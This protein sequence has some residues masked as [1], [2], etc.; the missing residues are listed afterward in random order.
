M[1]LRTRLI[2]SFTVVVAGLVLCLVVFISL[3]N[4]RQVQNYMLRGGM[5]GFQDTV[6][7]LEDFYRTHG[8]WDGVD[9]IL[10]DS[11]PMN[12]MR[13]NMPG[14]PDRFTLTDAN[15]L[16]VWS[17]AGEKTGAKLETAVKNQ[18]IKLESTPGQ[19][20]G[21]LIVS[22]R[23]AFQP[24]QV[25]PLITTLRNT[26]LRIGLI[27]GL[28]ALILA[29]LVANR[30][31]KPVKILTAAADSLSH[32]DL[33][34]RVKLK[35]KD[36]IAGLGNTFNQMAENLEGAEKRKK[37][38]TADIAHELRSP[39]AVQKAQLEAMQDGI[40]P[41][42]NESLQT[43]VDQTNFLTRLVDDLRTLALVDASELPLQMEE[44]NLIKLIDQVVERF[45]LQAVQQKVT[46]EFHNIPGKS[47]EPVNGDPD[48]LTQ[49]FGNLITNALHHTQAQGS[50]I[51]ELN[52]KKESFIASIKDTGCGIPPEELPHLFERFYRGDKSRNRDN[53]G[54]TGLGL[55]IARHLAR[56]HGGDLT[57]ANGKEGGAVFTLTLPKM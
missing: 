22:G 43:V 25:S 8:S 12:M 52:E 9:Q 50:I 18:S 48:R 2:L 7:N 19:V 39:L 17:S 13:N 31:I 29:I 21:Y 26:V 11:Q 46:L 45:S 1:S 3:D 40:V 51:I 37:A 42:N 33:S 5:F 32:G 41:I 38:L 53:S 23:E 14:N 30:L 54:S 4:T 6:N 15:L 44:I 20:I 10:P 57:A 16:V 47:T 35:G 36:E 34:V 27:A 49:I 28:I 24:A 56:V 55:S